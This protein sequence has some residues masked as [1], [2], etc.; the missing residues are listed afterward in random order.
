MSGFAD[1]FL[2][3]YLRGSEQGLDLAQTVER[4]RL[5]RE[6]QAM[7][8]DQ[9]N[10]DLQYRQERTAVDDARAAEYL[11]VQ[12]AYL[13][14][15]QARA[16]AVAEADAREMA[17][18]RAAQRFNAGEFERYSPPPVLG[19][20]GDMLGYAGR[21]AM[22]EQMDPRTQGRVLDDLQQKRQTDIETIRKQKM[23]EELTKELA[24]VGILLE[25]SGGYQAASRDPVAG[26]LASK[27]ESTYAMLQQLKTGIPGAAS[28]SMSLAGKTPAFRSQPNER[29][30]SN[31][32][33]AFQMR[34]KLLGEITE[35]EQALA[36]PGEQV[37]IGYDKMSAPIGVPRAEAIRLLSGKKAHL[38]ALLGDNAI[39]AGAVQ[40]GESESAPAG[41]D[42]DEE[43]YRLFNEI[44]NRK[45]ND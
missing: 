43:E 17:Q 19:G 31:M 44:L 6:Q 45:G 14:Q 4:Q 12:Q 39:G 13:A 15:S 30:P 40:G 18:Q 7:N 35:L 8:Q 27:Y 41:A 42:Q 38:N 36:T 20:A 2:A 9:F 16:A 25:K 3:A 33:G 21:S 37:V 28:S 32:A 10:R 23:I 24:A 11:K 29:D 1:P 5:L 22:F 34:A 26:M